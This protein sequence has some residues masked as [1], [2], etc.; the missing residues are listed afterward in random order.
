MI[1]LIGGVV[2]VIQYVYMTIDPEYLVWQ[3]EIQENSGFG[4]PRDQSQEI[5]EGMQNFMDF[6]GTAE[7][8]AIVSV[9]MTIFAGLLFGAVVS[10]ILKNEADEY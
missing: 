10:A 5:P 1:A 4:P 3:K 9:L 6:A 8:S 7:F 2:A